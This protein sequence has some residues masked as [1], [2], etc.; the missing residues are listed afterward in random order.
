TLG[1]L[2]G[3]IAIEAGAKIE[4]IAVDGVT[5]L[6]SRVPAAAYDE[7]GLRARLA[8]P[9]WVAARACAHDAVLRVASERGPVLP[10]RLCAVYEDD[11]R[12]RAILSR[13]RQS[14][15]EALRRLEGHREWG[16]RVHVEAE[17]LE[18]SGA[19]AA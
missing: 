4:R 14:I 6:V 5:A 12:V 15:D 13:N 11:E 17:A 2:D 3:A 18:P 10:L 19:A 7:A 1:S 8:D 16:V 9:E